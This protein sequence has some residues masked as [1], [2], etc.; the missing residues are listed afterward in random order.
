[1]RLHVI[2]LDHKADRPDCTEVLVHPIRTEVVQ[3]VLRARV[4]IRAGEVDTHL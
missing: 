1:M 4:S 3:R 2:I